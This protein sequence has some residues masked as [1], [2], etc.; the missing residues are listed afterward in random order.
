MGAVMED[1]SVYKAVKRIYKQWINMATGNEANYS[2]LTNGPHELV[3][4]QQANDLAAT[5]GEL[6]SE[7][8]IEKEAN[9]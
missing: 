8:L 2:D 9:P 7:K 3:K 4:F 5:L 1:S 6:N